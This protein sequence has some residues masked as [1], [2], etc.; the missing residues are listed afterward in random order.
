M[1]NLST[2]VKTTAVTA[3]LLASTTSFAA[4]IDANANVNDIAI[5]GYDTVAYF[6]MNKPVMGSHEFT[7]TYKNAIFQFANAKHR[8]L[9]KA[10]ATKYAPQFGGYC[11]MGTAMNLKFDTDPT[12]WKIVDEKLYLNLNKDVQKSWLKDVPGNLKTAETNWP[13][14]KLLTPA[15]AKA[16]NG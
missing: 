12:A 16:K 6:T 14:L 11:A 7:A 15:Q 1:M 13:A 3:V 4:D 5:K 9:F 8:D 2:L 10:D